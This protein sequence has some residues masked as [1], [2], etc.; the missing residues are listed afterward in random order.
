MIF[1]KNFEIIITLFF[2]GCINFYK[3]GNVWI[4]AV[5]NDQIIDASFGYFV[6]PILSVFLG[7]VFF[8][9][10]LNKKRK[11]AIALVVSS[12]IFLLID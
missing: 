6:M 9:E 4:Y 11:I 2:S 8:K 7:N 10:K 12:I 1:V 5:S 3:L